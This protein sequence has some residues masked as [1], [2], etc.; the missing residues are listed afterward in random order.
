M[1]YDLSTCPYLCIYISV[2]VVNVCLLL[3]A[4]FCI[5]Q[6]SC[7]H[8]CAACLLSATLNDCVYM[9][10]CLPVCSNV[11][12]LACMLLMG[13]HCTAKR[14]S[15]TQYAALQFYYFLR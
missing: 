4:Y 8:S 1:V 15:V 3:Y 5:V 10:V 14:L 12:M 7:I 2:C 13:L 9:S 11:C 6:V